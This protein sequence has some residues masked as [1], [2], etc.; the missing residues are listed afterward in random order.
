[1]SNELKERE[2]R[3]CSHCLGEVNPEDA[4]YDEINGKKLVFCCTG[5]DA[6]YR[7]I[8]EQGLD[9]FYEKRL[10]WRPGRPEIKEVREEEFSEFI[11][12]ISEN[13][14]EL[15]FIISGIRCASCIWLI[16]H[17]IKKS[18]GI[19]DMRVNYAT[20]RARLR[21]NP[22]KIDLNEILKKITS[23]GYIPKPAY[24][25]EGE[26]ELRREKRDLLIRFGTASFFSMQLMIYTSALYA[27]YFQGIEET[28][29]R[30]FQIIAW[31]LATPVMFYCGY[32]FMK[33]A[34]RGL[35]NKTFN[36]DVLIFLGSFSA[37][38]YSV[39]IIILNILQ[40]SSRPFAVLQP[41]KAEVYFDTSSMIITLILLGRFIEQGAKVKAFSVIQALLGLQPKEAR[42]I[43]DSEEVSVKINELKEGDRI[44]IKPGERI[45]VDGVVIE[46]HSEVD[47]S[48]LTGES[49]P[50]LKPPGL[51][52]FAG[53]L[54]IN[55]RLIV[56]VKT[57][58]DTV[59]SKIT[60]AVL[61][62][63]AR[64]A[65]IQGIA[66]RVTGWFVPFIILTGLLTFIYWSINGDSKIALMNA[67]SVLVIACPCALGLATPLAMLT[68]STRLYS[69][70]IIIKEGNVI[71]QIAHADTICIDKTG[72]LTEGRPE[73]LEIIAYDRT[74]E[75][76][77]IIAASLEQ[78]SEHVIAKAITKG[79]KRD[80]LISVSDFQSF[81]GL[82]VK[83]IIDKDRVV[84]GNMRFLEDS[85]VIINKKQKEDF[86]NFSEKGYTIIGIAI[87][88]TLSGWLIISDKVAPGAGDV[89]KELKRLKKKVILLTGDH[90]KVAIE[91]GKIL[92]IGEIYA[93]V[94]P[95]EKSDI[96]KKFKKA[97][98]KVMMVGD[99]IN[100]APA[101]TEADAGIATGGATD[102]AM[103]SAGAVLM[104]NDIGLLI[105]LIRISQKTLS[106]IKQ[107]LFWAF[108]YNIIAIPLAVSGRIH[109]IISAILMATSSLMVVGNSLRLRR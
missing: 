72:T 65:R 53:T 30:L 35:R 57:V 6:I 3:L 34:I 102:I 52:V 27:G 19:I 38:A 88:N 89:I 80:K 18:E 22:Q 33:N 42:L 84:I 23:L 76:L 9:E 16:E 56:R 107:N 68:G 32:P 43:S 105:P 51:E 104:R 77:H 37:Y 25:A 90:E 28:Y 85:G 87:N 54:N 64:R 14:H 50:V 12:Q 83:G 10:G 73:L 4:I 94:L 49:M 41:S 40:P 61:E 29:R 71:E 5:C 46:G 15:E 59:L 2:Q 31:A 44:I 13:H 78:A 17:L 79:V 60:E 1:M 55:G 103:E 96:I 47:E 98:K 106:I 20:H 11:K 21:W 100:D 93:E 67:V 82:G 92:G 86:L 7:L 75:E 8:H 99:G 45:P 66:D 91:T 62:A 36:M 95:V 109:P 26:D 101:L 69:S 39:A 81:S 58:K 108:S 74:K 97:K 70:G 48:M 24:T 63:Q